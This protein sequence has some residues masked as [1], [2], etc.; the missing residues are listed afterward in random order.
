MKKLRLLSAVCACVSLFVFTSTNA[1]TIIYQFDGQIFGAGLGGI[2]DGTPYS[3]EFSYED[4]SPNLGTNPSVGVYEYNYFEVTIGAD[5][6]F[7]DLTGT[8]SGTPSR[9][10]ISNSPGADTMNVNANPAGGSVGTYTSVLA[11]NVAF[12]DSDVFNDISLPGNN[13]TIDD[14][15]FSNFSGLATL[16]NGVVVDFGGTVES[17]QAVPLPAALW[18]FG[19]GLIGLIGLARRKKV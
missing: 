17:L 4:N 10:F 11:F 19:S 13:L 5:T 9:I 7:A 16:S 1:A 8:T 12:T 18:L 2:P 3:G 6:I 15:Q 14:F